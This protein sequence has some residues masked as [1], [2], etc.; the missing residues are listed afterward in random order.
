[1]HQEHAMSSLTKTRHRLGSAEFLHLRGQPVCLFAERGTLWV[2]QDGEPEDIQL[3]AGQW[4]RFDGHAAIMVGTLGGEAQV[5]VTR[6]AAP[7]WTL[8]GW[9]ARVR[10][11]RTLWP[12]TLAAGARA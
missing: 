2:T 11:W 12:R 1:M 4:Q 8:A 3:D 9:A 5:R 7:A 6:F 10:H